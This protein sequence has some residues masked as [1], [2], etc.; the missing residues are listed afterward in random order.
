MKYS[1]NIVIY[2]AFIFTTV[3]SCDKSKEEPVAQEPTT[4]VINF[5]GFE[6]IVRTSDAKKQ[7][8]GP[9]LFSNSEDNVW[10]DNE[11]RLHLKI[12]EKGGNWYCSGITLRK[13]YGFKK[14]VIYVASRVD[15][16]DE[17][18]VGGLFTYK[19]DDEEIDI[20][21][22]RWSETNNQNS[23]FAVQPSY[24]SGNKTRYNLNLTSNLSTHFFD[25]QADKIEF[26]SY[27]GHTLNP[28]SKDIISTWTYTGTNIPPENEE[29]FKI[30]LW[31]FRGNAPTNKESAEMIIER[32]EIL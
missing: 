28:D 19:N 1:I 30:N 12:I 25:W 7:G 21:F 31:L 27:Q 29:R 10:V 16:L 9:N 24:I 15:Q 32:I 13:T 2:V 23:Q 22:S 11:G 18:V 5:S 14:Y 20:E 4:R 3:S 6:W 26:G 17:N 8:P